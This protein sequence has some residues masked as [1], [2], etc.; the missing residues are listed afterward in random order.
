MRR[1][2]FSRLVGGLAGTIAV[3]GL[4]PTGA[5]AHGAKLDYKMEMAPKIALQA[6]YDAGDPMTM[7]QVTVYAPN[8]PGKPWLTGKT[9]AQGRFAFSPDTS[10]PGEWAIQAR[11]AGHG[12]MIHIMIG[13][14][15]DPAV[16]GASAASQAAVAAQSSAP[17]SPMQ[18]WMMGASVIW[19]FVGTGLFF[20]R[21]KAA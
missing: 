14:S 19:G 21:K 6:K 10:I 18:R 1:I 20:S 3:L 15:A 16:A 11:E 13:D 7:A 12:S 8:D 4:L 2:L 9:D 17:Q 5:Q